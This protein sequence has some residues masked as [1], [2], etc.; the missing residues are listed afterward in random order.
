MG[1]VRASVKFF[2]WGMCACVGTSLAVG[3]ETD[4]VSKIREEIS[5]RYPKMQISSVRDTKIKGP[6][7][8]IVA[9]TNVIYYDQSGGNLFFGEIWS[10]E[11]VSLTAKTRD[12]VVAENS[13]GNLAMLR[14]NLDKAVKVGSGK[15]EVIELTD[16]DCPYCRKMAE[17]WDKRDDVTRYVFLMP[18]PTLHPKAEAK[19]KFVLASADKAKALQDVFKGNYDTSLPTAGDDKGLFEIHK[20]LTVKSGLNGTPAYFVDGVFVHG[21]NVPEIEKAIGKGK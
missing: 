1:S 2:V 13:K 3:A 9:G 4:D 20:Q 21:A 12:A 14:A 16:P 11:G 19:S 17:Y 5:L 8:E 15:H 7:Y 18:I 10:K 6:L